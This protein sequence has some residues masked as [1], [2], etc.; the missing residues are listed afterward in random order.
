MRALDKL[1]KAVSMAAV[2]KSIELPDGSEFEFHMTPLTLAE[3]AKAQKQAKTDDSID[4]ALQLLVTKAKD[5]SGRP[6]FNVGEIAELRNELPASVVEDLMLKLI[7]GEDEEDEDETY[8]MKSDQ[9][10]AE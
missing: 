3:R 9:E 8:D 10:A 5:K 6:L 4:Y 2:R 7:G 1:K